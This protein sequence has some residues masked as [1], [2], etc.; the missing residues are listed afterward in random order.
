LQ[1]VW[2]NNKYATNLTGR[3]G[4]TSCPNLFTWPIHYFSTIWY[5]LFTWPIHYFST[6]SYDLL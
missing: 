4:Q 2:E 1:K 6:I 5:D 3:Q